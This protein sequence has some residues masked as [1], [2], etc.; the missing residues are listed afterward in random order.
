M[1]IGDMNA[2][3]LTPA[4]PMR[5]QIV[6]ARWDDRLDR[7]DAARNAMQRDRLEKDRP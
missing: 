1:S 2:L 5:V 4:G 6:A 7:M 3:V